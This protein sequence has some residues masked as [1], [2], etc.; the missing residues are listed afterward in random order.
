[1]KRFF[2]LLFLSVFAYAEVDIILDC[3]L[4]NEPDFETIMSIPSTYKIGV[5]FIQFADWQTD[6]NARGSVQ[7]IVGTDTTFYLYEDYY[8]MLFS[9]GT[10]KTGEPLDPPPDDIFSPDGRIIYGSMRDYYKEVSYNQFNLDPNCMIVNDTEVIGEDNRIIWITAPYD[11]DYYVAHSAIY[12]L[13]TFAINTASTNGWYDSSDSIDCFVVV[14]A[15]YMKW[16][17]TESNLCPCYMGNRFITCER[18]GSNI[19]N[20]QLAGIYTYCHEFGHFLGLG[21]VYG[22]GSGGSRT[23]DGVGNFSLMGTWS[24]NVDFIGTPNECPPHISCVEK[25]QLDWLSPTDITSD[26]SITI[27]D[28]ETNDEAY[29]YSISLA[30]S[31]NNERFWIENRQPV[32]FDLMY[33]NPN[34]LVGGGLLIY[35]QGVSRYYTDVN[36]MIKL[37]EADG[38]NDLSRKYGDQGA[39]DDFFPSI[40]DGNP[41]NYITDYSNDT[42]NFYLVFDPQPSH[43]ALFNISDSDDIMTTDIYTNAWAGTIS[44]NT[45]WSGEDIYIYDELH[46]EDNVIVTTSTHVYVKQGVT[47]SLDPGATLEFSSGKKMDVKGTLSCQGTSGNP[48][49]ITSSQ[50]TPS[51]GSWYGIV[52]GSS[53][54]FDLD[55]T[56]VEYATYGLRGMNSSGDIDNCS[57][58]NNS[59]GIYLSDEGCSITGCDFLNNTYGAVFLYATQCDARGCTFE[60]NSSGGI[61]YSQ[62]SGYVK[63]CSF[64]GNNYGLYMLNQSSPSF[65]VCYDDISANNSIVNNTTAGVYISSNSTPDLGTYNYYSGPDITWGGFS[66]FEPSASGYDIKNYNGTTI[67]AEVNFWDDMTNYGSVDTNPTGTSLGFSFSK[68]TNETIGSQLY[69]EAY[70]L[71][72][73]EEYSEAIKAYNSIIDELPND[74]I[75]YSAIQGLV[76]VYGKLDNNNGLLE[77]LDKISGGYAD[78]LASTIALENSAIAYI[79]TG[80][81]E[82]ALRRANITVNLY[83]SNHQDKEAEAWAMFLRGHIS[84]LIENTGYDYN[85]SKCTGNSYNEIYSSIVKNYAGTEAAG[86]I[87]DSD[88]VV[89]DS[90]PQVI[91]P[92]KFSLLQNFPNPF[93][94][95]TT[96]TYEL[97]EESYV[98]VSVF[99]I[100][101]RLVETL[102]NQNQNAGHYDIQWNASSHPSGV[103]FYQI[104]AGNFQQV[105]KCLLVK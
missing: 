38:R 32:G 16:D 55:Y 48:V 24:Y 15:G 86:F 25:Y 8:N 87:F 37:I 26:N 18:N 44:S 53:G 11:R 2:L 69:S 78:N 5:I 42:A 94:P 74:P 70:M 84:E 27:Q 59:Y 23:K 100:S 88:I 85:L 6:F 34:T 83:R 56:T 13:T 30:N 9:E 62:A 67:K 101:G 29:R 14:Y 51:K 39:L 103:Y 81:L 60:G 50:A 93:N 1:M 64:C 19:N 57:F 80:N 22:N 43:F 99:D 75:V 96:F 73:C 82:E 58:E 77:N 76:R 65:T 10:Y 28:V 31:S 33:Q 3:Q 98:T 79:K 92:D 21:D 54:S 17:G 52:V 46:I 105:K 41:I 35:R 104:M 40:I 71:E 7:D 68:P 36:E 90:V 45:T 63:E 61:G 4:S 72:L 12:S 66:Y 91:T 102:I 49:V 89:Y 95:V 47:L 97:P 20:N